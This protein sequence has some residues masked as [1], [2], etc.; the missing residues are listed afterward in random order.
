MA[1][2]PTSYLD[3][4]ETGAST[5][6][7]DDIPTQRVEPLAL[8][9]ITGYV[10]EQKPPYEEFN[11]LMWNAGRWIRWIMDVFT[12]NT[13]TV[14]MGADVDY[15]DINAAIAAGKTRI[16]LISN[17]IVG[18]TQDFTL[19]NGSLKTNGFQIVNSAGL[20]P[21]GA[22]LTISGSNNEIDVD[23]NC[24]VNATTNQGLL[25]TGSSNDIKVR[26][27]QGNAA[28]TI[29]SG[30]RVEGDGNRI[31]GFV[32]QTAAGTITKGVTF[33]AGGDGNQ[34]DLIMDRRIGTFPTVPPIYTDAGTANDW[35][36]VDIT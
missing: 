22:V 33:A 21:A 26:I 5:S 24:T 8:E 15:A 13:V 17:L 18:T 2:K 29:T 9:K 34:C 36:I 20:A 31:N 14:G 27:N 3:W 1:K 23:I 12:S 11:W 4:T 30:I 28:G 7:T 32:G 19:S 35:R 10:Y 16:I 6:G 25:V